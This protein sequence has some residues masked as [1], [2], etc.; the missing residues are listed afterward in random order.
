MKVQNTSIY[1]GRTHVMDIDITLK[2]IEAWK[3]AA[4]DDPNR[5]IQNAFPQLSADQREFMISGV[6]PDEWAELF[7]EGK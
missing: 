6:T 4:D 2:Q 7:G 3:N 1:T 5:F